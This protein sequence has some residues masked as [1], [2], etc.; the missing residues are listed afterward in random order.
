MPDFGGGQAT[1]YDAYLEARFSPTLRLRAGKFKP[2][3]GIERLQSATDLAFAERALPTNLVPNRDLG[4]QLSGDLL[5]G[6]LG[7]A[8]GVFNGTV[9]LGNGDA[10]SNDAKDVEA[11][12]FWRPFQPAASSVPAIDLGL[13]VGAGVGR[14][15]GTATAPGLPSYRA[16]SQASFFAYRSDGT[17]TGTAIADGRQTR[18]SPQGWLYVGSWGVL[19]EGVRSTQRVARGTS[20]VEL[21]H[22]AWQVTASWALTG[23]RLSY[24]GVVPRHDF[25]P[26]TGGWG[27]LVL[28]ARAS[29]LALDDRTFP[30]YANPASAARQATAWAA[31]LSWYLNRGVR[32]LL[33]YETTRFDGG[34]AARD[35]ETEKVLFSRFQIS[36]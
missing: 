34:D 2:P 22:D 32:L 7:Y 26:A 14:H 20:Q 12:L 17:A 31:G 18:I 4:I 36:F 30:T 1:L 23:E 9:D 8:L 28:A 21:D 19:A 10:D 13:G 35:R 27:A 29:S 11:R 3:V 6:K 24:R 16:P 33:D 15:E 25:A 5:A